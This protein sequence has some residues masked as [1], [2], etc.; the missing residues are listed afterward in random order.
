MNKP[1]LQGGTT[2]AVLHEQRQR[3][4][5]TCIQSDFVSLPP[6]QIVPVL[7]DRS[8]DI[9]SERSSYLEGHAHGQSRRGGGSVLRRSRVRFRA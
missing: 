1:Q 9:S 6:G 2:T 7:A 4:L 3:I 8:F 5:L